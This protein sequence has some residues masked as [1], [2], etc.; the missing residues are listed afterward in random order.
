MGKYLG[1]MLQ[2]FQVIRK[3]GGSEDRQTT[4]TNWQENMA[5]LPER[6]LHFDQAFPEISDKMGPDKNE[7]WLL[8][9]AGDE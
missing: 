1:L 2:K 7:S 8:P 9:R 5:S 3:S 4:W 6:V